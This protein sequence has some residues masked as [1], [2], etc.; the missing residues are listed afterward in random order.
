MPA[1]RRQHNGERDQHNTALATA[2]ALQAFALL[3]ERAT[4][5]LGLLNE[6]LQ[7]EMEEGEE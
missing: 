2:S 5:T 7:R 1:P 6:L 4:Y 3:C